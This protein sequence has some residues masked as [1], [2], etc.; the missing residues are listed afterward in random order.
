MVVRVLFGREH[1]APGL[2]W[3]AYAAYLPGWDILGVPADQLDRH[4]D[5]VDVLCSFGAQVDAQLL[6]SG[7]FGLVQQ[8]G[9]GLERVDVEAATAA[10]VWV[11][12]LPAELTGNAD[13]VAD[14]ALL[15]ILASLRR[16]DA[17][18]AGLAAGRWAEPAG[19]TL[20]GLTVVVV[21]LGGTGAATVERLRGFGCEVV[22]V[23]AHP[24]RGGPD[25]LK[26]VVGPVEL[27]ELVAGADVLVLCPLFEPGVPPLVDANLLDAVRPGLVLVN[28]ARGGLVDESALLAALQD[29]R[30]AAAGL[31]VF[32]CE[33]VDPQAPLV[34]HP[35]VIALPHVAGVTEQMFN[36]AG[37]VFADELERWRDH[38]PPRYAVNQPPRP[39]GW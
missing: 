20:A 26:A 38:E 32:A 14:T 6:Q 35:N 36:Q 23:R 13:G 27:L 2:E 30:V 5:G 25:G 17:A 28:V 31:D 19:R 10:G 16:L 11:A 24:E 21:G 8:L 22:G 1:Y 33:P 37:R 3:S 18:R 39:R 9:V 29:G 12:R 4:L 34:T 15:L 7:T